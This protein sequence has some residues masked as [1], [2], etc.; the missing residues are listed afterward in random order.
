MTSIKV[1]VASKNPV[2]I[3]CTSQAFS[4]AFPSAIL[5]VQG[6]SVPSNV[7]DQPMTDAET[8]EG[9]KNRAR[10]AQSAQP[11]ADY[12]VGIEG[13]I[14]QE[15]GTMEAFAW[16]SIISKTK[17]GKARTASFDLP[18]KIRALVNQGVELGHADDM[19]FERTNS[20]QGNGAVGILTNGL[21]DRAAYYEPAVVLALIPFLNQELY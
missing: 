5:D 13:G 16:I 17:E 11:D 7:S 2:K 10:N 14:N 12:W 19:V 4:K 3:N 18:E 1:V 6:V 20:K 9:A 8:L 15:S 21:I